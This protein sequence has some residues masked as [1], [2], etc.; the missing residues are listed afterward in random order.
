MSLFFA[1]ARIYLLTPAHFDPDIFIYL[2]FYKW[3]VNFI[4]YY[5]GKRIFDQQ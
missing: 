2:G 5:L 1:G 3:A 4:F